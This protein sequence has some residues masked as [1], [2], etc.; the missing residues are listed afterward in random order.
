MSENRE[1]FM[2]ALAGCLKAIPEI[3]LAYLHGSFLKEETYEDVDLALVMGESG[4][5][6]QLVKLDI[7]KALEARLI[8]GRD[9]HPW[10]P[11]EPPFSYF[12]LQEMNRLPLHLRHKIIVEG[13]CLYAKDELARMRFE[14]KIINK[15][16]DFKPVDDYFDNAALRRFR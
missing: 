9:F 8:P 7:L 12:D 10:Q 2:Q 3:S 16:L 4:R 15:A 5:P 14:E 11:P 13:L 1:V 6:W